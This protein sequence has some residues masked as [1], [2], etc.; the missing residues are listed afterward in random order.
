[1]QHLSTKSAV[2]DSNQ[3]EIP[4]AWQESRIE[5]SEEQPKRK[6]K[7]KGLGRTGIIESIPV[8]EDNI[9][10]GQPLTV[11]ATVPDTA[12]TETMPIKQEISGCK[13]SRTYLSYKVTRI[14]F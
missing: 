8:E 12:V 10:I 14:N 9:D 7:E 4:S 13:F 6:V 5:L 11:V 3:Q 2:G 1:M